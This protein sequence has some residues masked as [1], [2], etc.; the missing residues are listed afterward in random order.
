MLTPVDMK[1][2]SITGH[3]D[4]LHKLI[5]TLH[6][7]KVID[8][9]EH[10]KTD[11][12]N[13]GKPFKDAEELSK[14]LLQVNAL[15]SQLNIQ[16]QEFSKNIIDYKEIK[17]KIQNILDES[18][19]LQDS[20]KEN[21]D[22]LTKKESLLAE[23][24]T[25]K[26]IDVDLEHLNKEFDTLSCFVGAI[27]NPYELI[28]PI[29]KITQDH[30]LYLSHYKK[31]KV[32]VIFVKK[33]FQEQVQ[34]LLTK[35]AFIAINT[36]NLINLKSTAKF[37]IKKIEQD[38]NTLKR[39]LGNSNTR[40]KKLAKLHT[41]F[42]LDA[43]GFLETEL[44]IEEAPLK[45]AA[46]DQTFFITGW[47]LKKDI[48]KITSEIQK[49]SNNI[50]IEIKDPEKNDK[51]PVQLNNSKFA[52]PFETFLDL[53]T[54]PKYKEIDPT[55]IMFITFPFLFG[56]MLGDFGYGL[57]TLGLFHILKKKIPKAAVFF[58]V[59]I[60]SSLSTIL[61]GLLFGEFFGFEQFGNFHLPHILSRSHDITQLLMLALAVGVVH[62][63]F[64]LILGFIN[65][66]R[67]HSFGKA[68]LAK[69]G[70]FVLQAGVVLLY[71]AITKQI[72]LYPYVGGVVIFIAAVMLFFGEGMMGLIELPGIFV[73]ITSYARLM[74]IGVSSVK[75][76]EVINEFGINFIASGGALIVAGVSIMIIGHLINI[77]LGLVGSFLHSLRLHYVEF[78]SKFLIGGGR[79]FKAFGIKEN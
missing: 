16:K 4:H 74:A 56:F 26:N 43:K 18:N 1:K 76:A 33:E 28:E 29:K 14:T 48:N 42:L 8:I 30:K 31:E 23:L 35:N 11:E 39:S 63:N 55:F 19:D 65:E 5:T 41:N 45:L 59:L 32:F 2:L 70:W 36:N 12:L 52:K 62:I 6:D 75:L 22:K 3:K 51:V 68:V 60:L 57:F 15:I 13:M 27:K 37:N 58:N 66:V 24:Q 25:F 61:F 34:K 9:I 71:L 10:K 7:L 20:I 44:E 49:I 40:F 21:I 53:Y 67:L 69:G 78:F 38:I 17:N 77:T 50:Y 64:G 47:I 54:L 72:L 73:N 79:R 46:T